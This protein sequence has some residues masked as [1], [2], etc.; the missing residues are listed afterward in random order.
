MSNKPKILIVGTGVDHIDK[1]DLRNA[2]SEFALVEDIESNDSIPDG[3]YADLNS[4]PEFL[5]ELVN[6]EV[7]RV[8]VSAIPKKKQ[9]MSKG[10]KHRNRKDRWT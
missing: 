3:V 4:E 8:P 7:E 5:D 1:R 9:R 6:T 10:E 2:L